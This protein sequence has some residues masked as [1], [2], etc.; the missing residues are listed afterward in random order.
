MENNISKGGGEYHYADS[1]TD[2]QLTAKKSQCTVQSRQ[3]PPPRTRAK[4]GRYFTGVTESSILTSLFKIIS[5][6]IVVT[7]DFDF[8]FNLN[9]LCVYF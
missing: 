3:E 6:F 2:H 5:L 9:Y 1:G 4:G 8:V 7:D